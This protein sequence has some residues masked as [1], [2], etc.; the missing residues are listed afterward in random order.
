MQFKMMRFS[1]DNCMND[2]IN[3]DNSYGDNTTGSCSSFNNNNDLEYS[4]PIMKFGR[5]FRAEPGTHFPYPFWHKF[6]TMSRLQFRY[7]YRKALLMHKMMLRGAFSRKHDRP[8]K[9][10]G[11]KTRLF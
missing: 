9:K 2:Y 3:F 4:A 7:T 8:R 10:L 1:Q 11:Q 6:T 5:G